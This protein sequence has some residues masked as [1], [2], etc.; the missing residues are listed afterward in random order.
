MPSELNLR[1]LM[2]E[3]RTALIRAGIANPALDVRL[4]TENATGLSA[5]ELSTNPDWTVPDDMVRLIRAT[6]ERRANHEPVHRILGYREFYG[7]HLSLSQATLEPRPDTEALVDIVVPRAREIAAE[8]GKCH[9][10]DLGTGTGAIALALLDQVANATAVATDISENALVTARKNALAHG[11]E[12]R[13]ETLVSDWFANVDRK[14]HIIVSNPPY[15]PTRSLDSLDREVRDHDPKTALDG[16]RDGLEAYRS[17]AAEVREYLYP[18]GVVGVEVGHDQRTAVTAIF[19]A[20]EFREI[21]CI[22]DLGGHDRALLF[23]G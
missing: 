6:V 9:I 1:S 23:A 5:L 17:I 8:H 19:G 13:I 20:A 14:F 16:G 15:I 22:A 4:L 12:D 3:S 21:A 18:Q 11:L 10:L 7:L 2:T